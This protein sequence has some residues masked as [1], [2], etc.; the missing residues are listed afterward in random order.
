MYINKQN[1]YKHNCSHGA[2][3]VLHVKQVP[4]LEAKA[5]CIAAG[6]LMDEAWISLLFSPC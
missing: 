3:G 1:Q 5:V 6:V 2:F 4:S